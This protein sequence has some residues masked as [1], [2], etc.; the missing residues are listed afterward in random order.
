MPLT[1]CGVRLKR[2]DAPLLSIMRRSFQLPFHRS[3]R[4][5]FSAASFSTDATDKSHKCINAHEINCLD[6]TSRE[7]TK[8]YRLDRRVKT[9][10]KQRTLFLSSRRRSPGWFISVTI[11]HRSN[12]LTIISLLN[13][14][15]RAS[16]RSSAFCPRR[17]RSEARVTRR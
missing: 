3:V 16:N 12:S 13:A 2:Y 7:S 5:R 14:A 10:D 6:D 9:R 17:T 1:R 15:I 4:E 11:S 8:R